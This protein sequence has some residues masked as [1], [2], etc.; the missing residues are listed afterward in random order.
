MEIARR[1]QFHRDLVS[2][3]LTRNISKLV[4]RIRM[5]WLNGEDLAEERLGVRQPPGTVVL[6]RDL[7]GL[8][9]CHG[10]DLPSSSIGASGLSDIE[11]ESGGRT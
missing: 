4:Q 3:H 10:L 8:W 7:K 2:T 1:D 6:D 11:C 9:N 5:V